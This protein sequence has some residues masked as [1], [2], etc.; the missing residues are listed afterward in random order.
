[1]TIGWV[2]IWKFLIKQGLYVST[3]CAHIQTNFSILYLFHSHQASTIHRAH[4]SFTTCRL[5]LLI[6]HLYIVTR[7]GI[8][9]GWLISAWCWMCLISGYGL[10]IDGQ[11]KRAGTR[12]YKWGQQVLLSTSPFYLWSSPSS[13]PIIQ[14]GLESSKKHLNWA[15]H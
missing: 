10:A 7:Q 13:F 11:T 15:L 14:E 3:S 2:C 6:L 5:W 1:M 9:D 12:Q 4:S 8:E